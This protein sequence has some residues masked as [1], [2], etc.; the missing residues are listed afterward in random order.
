LSNPAGPPR[1]PLRVAVLCH[2]HHLGGHQGHVYD[3]L[4]RR[5]ALTLV[6]IEEDGWP[7][8]LSDLPEGGEFDAILWQVKGRLLR[9]RSP[10]D[11]Q[12]YS[13]P[14]I[15]LAHDT[16]RS[17]MQI[18]SGSDTLGMWPPMIHRQGFDLVLVSGKRVCELLRDDGVPAVWMPKAY[19]VDWLFDTGADR[20]GIGYYGSLYPARRAMLDHLDRSS[21]TVRRFQCPESELNDHLNRCLGVVICNMG[22]PL[23][24]S[25]GDKANRHFP[26]RANGFT[27][28]P[29]TMLKNFEIAAAGTVPFCDPT[30]DLADLGFLDGHTAMVYST[31]DDLLDRLHT[32]LDQPDQLREIGRRAAH[33][34]HAQHTWDHRAAFLEKLLH[35]PDPASSKLSWDL[36]ERTR[37]SGAES[38]GRTRSTRWRQV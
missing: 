34:V 24:D 8:R 11:W 15:M 30:P 38:Q 7:Q 12:T 20:E 23:E 1:S 27:L 6:V 31:F 9:D 17:Y 16:Y 26:E 37:N 2:R 25:I 33:L 4:A 18:A 35:N 19:A 5:F 21:V 14:R 3:A 28:A 36:G 13:G 29:E 32:S 10:F 22:V